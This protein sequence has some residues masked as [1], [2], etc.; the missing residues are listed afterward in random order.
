VSPADLVGGL[1]A[2]WTWAGQ[3]SEAALRSLIRMRRTPS[4]FVVEG[5]PSGTVERVLAGDE[6]AWEAVEPF[7]ASCLRVGS[8]SQERIDRD[9]A[10]WR[11]AW[12]RIVPRPAGAGT[13]AAV[14]PSGAVRRL[15]SRTG[16][17]AGPA[18]TPAPVDDPY[19]DPGARQPT[20]RPSSMPAWRPALMTAA[21]VAVLFTAGA[22]AI[23][24]SADRGPA[25][26]PVPAVTRSAAPAA[27]APS[28]SPSPATSP[29]PAT[30]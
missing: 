28:A 27:Q 14:A 5:M 23:V 13:Q 9:L 18:G 17:L 26:R 7:V 1:R 22:W 12:H 11:D 30:R 21:A 2:L 24:G 15:L 25:P 20:G 19:R 10:A 3:P 4:G 29:T 8:Q 16:W 6:P